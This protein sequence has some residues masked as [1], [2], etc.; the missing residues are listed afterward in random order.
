[1]RL[2]LAFAVEGALTVV[3][4]AIS[5]WWLP[6]TPATCRFL[7]EAEKSVARAR[8]LRDGSI[9][10]DE[11]F[12]FKT[13]MSAFRGWRMWTY[14]LIS[15]TYAGAFST[16][17]SFL[18]QI[19]GRLGLSTVQTNLWTVAPNCV[20]VVVLLAVTWS[21]DHFRE[22]TFH[23][24]FAL[25]LP[26]VGMIILSSVNVLEQKGVAYFAMFLMAAGAVS[27]FPPSAYHVY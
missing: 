2:T 24:T 10:V 25:I 16:T 1:L 8:L 19:V 17:S 3:I 7:T 15:F 4:G 6:S 20:G 13:A 11:K 18:P 26:L 27:L 9:E 22:R 12:N 23:L 5:F 21:S 14:A